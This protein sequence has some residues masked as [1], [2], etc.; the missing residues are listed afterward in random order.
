MLSFPEKII[1]AIAAVITVVLVVRATIRIVR[2][3]R[4]PRDDKFLE[5]AV[6]GRADFV[7]TGDKDL[8]ALQP[9]A[10]IAIVTPADYLRSLDPD[11]E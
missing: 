4:D 7:I 8:L 5:A 1:F 6:N 2:A 9:F 10:G 11:S 3:C